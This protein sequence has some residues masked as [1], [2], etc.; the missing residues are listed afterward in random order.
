MDRTDNSALEAENFSEEYARERRK[1]T[2][3]IMMT[4][5]NETALKEYPYRVF[6]DM[7]L[8]CRIKEH[9]YSSACTSTAVTW[10]MLR[11][12]G[13]TEERLFRDTFRI[14]PLN[15]PPVFRKM[16]EMLQEFADPE[17]CIITGESPLYVATVQ[18]RAY[19]ASV[20]A[21][22]GFTEA[23]A[24]Y[25]NGDYY[26]IPSSVHEILILPEPCA[27]GVN[28]LE[29]M[30]VQINEKVVEP[31]ERLSDQV[32]HYDRK[33]KRIETGKECIERLGG[34]AG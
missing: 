9:N 20:M 19:G 25:I 8:I 17:Q 16:E 1:L 21:Y 15:E 22:P 18:S 10:E 12:W 26:I 33:R 4:K 28:D 13:V 32:Y 29:S 5:G 31:A 3:Q 27:P 23:A 14:A 34:T 30:I 2:F 11:Q 6:L 7:A 24:D